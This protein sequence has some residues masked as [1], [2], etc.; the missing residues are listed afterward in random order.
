LPNTYRPKILLVNDDSASLLALYSMLSQWEEQLDFHVMTAATGEEALRAVLQHDFSVILLDVNMPGMDGF[1]TAEAIHLRQRSAAVPIIFVTAYLADEMNRLK[2]Y[3]TGAVDY[4]FTPIIPQILYAKISVFVG[5]ARKNLELKRQTK[6][7]NANASEL[8]AANQRLEQE[9]RERQQAVQANR[10]KDDFLAMLGHELRNPLSAITSAASIIGLPNLAAEKEE[11]ARAIIRRQSQHLSR[12]VDDLLDLSRAMSGKIR[13]TRQPLDLGGLVET[14]VEVFRTTGRTTAYTVN[15]D[16]RPALI[17][18]D[19]ARIEQ[20]VSNLIDNALKYT[21]SGGV[22]DICT[23]ID[24]ADTVF[25]VRDSGLGIAADLL[26]YVFD[27]FV[28]GESTLDRAKGGLGLGLALVRQLVELHDGAVTVSSAGKGAGSEFTVRLP[29]SVIQA[30]P[31]SPVRRATSQPSR[32]LLIED[33]DDGREMLSAMLSAYGNEV[34][35]A[36]DS[37]EGLKLASSRRPD[38]AL[39]DIGL[40]GVDGY[41]IA[42]RL[43]A[44][45]G[46]RGIRLIALTGYGLPEDQRRALEAGFDMHLVKPVHAER[47]LDAISLYAPPLP[48]ALT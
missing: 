38:I 30:S 37:V 4:L 2:G 14:C 15:L 12:L 21:P 25:S 18:A 8:M 23:R 46:T 36:A 45:T 19:Q 32:I 1:E 34:F 22:I 3:Q 44:D 11:R 47:L 24:G 35:N 7:I 29:L 41:E 13:L 42:R 16:I 17:H 27:V 20:I 10:E 28:Q 6:E 40:P 39:I 9:I 43:R 26:P 48:P 5:L 31:E 33:N